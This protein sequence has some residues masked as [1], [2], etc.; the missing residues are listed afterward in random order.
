MALKKLIG[1]KYWWRVALGLTICLALV[2]SLATGQRDPYLWF[3]LGWIG[4]WYITTLFE[5]WL[6]GGADEKLRQYKDEVIRTQ[7]RILQ[8]MASRLREVE[9]RIGK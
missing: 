6:K 1:K 3:A 9:E 7:W 4:G 2:V 8:M 5:V